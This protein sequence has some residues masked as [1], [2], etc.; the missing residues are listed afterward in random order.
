MSI[1]KI[2]DHHLW[3]GG[4]DLKYAASTI[5]I[6]GKLQVCDYGDDGNYSD[7]G[8]NGVRPAFSINNQQIAPH[9]LIGICSVTSGTSF[10]I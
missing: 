4:R 8:N 3:S 7:Y 2:A 5:F 10:Q 1:R 6:S 9:C